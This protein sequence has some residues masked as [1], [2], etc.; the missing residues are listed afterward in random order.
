MSRLVGTDQA[1]AN[2]VLQAANNSD[3]TLFLATF[4]HMRYG[5]CEDYWAKSNTDAGIDDEF[6]NYSKLKKVVDLEGN[7]VAK[8]VV[9]D[10]GQLVQDVHFR[11]ERPDREAFQGYTGNEGA[12][13]TLWYRRAVRYARTPHRIQSD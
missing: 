3:M 9:V 4:E 12:E 10:D 6:D 11:E 5:T 1:M 7:E 13:K 2:Q 8:N